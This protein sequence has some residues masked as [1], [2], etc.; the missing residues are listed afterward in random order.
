[1]KVA[2]SFQTLSD[3]VPFLIDYR[4]G[5][6]NHVREL[7]RQAGAPE[8][9]HY[10]AYA[11]NTGALC[12][13]ENFRSAGGA[14]SSREIAL[15]KA[16]GE[17]IE[18]YCCAMY[19][20]E[21][22]PLFS[23][24]AAPFPCVSPDTFALYTERQYRQPAF[25]YVPFTSQVPIRWAR[26]INL[27]NG[28][29]WHVPAAMTVLPYAFDEVHGER[30]VCQR[31]STGL[32]CHRSF[33]EAA[34]SGICEVIERDA[35]TI[36]WQAQLA[37][38][39]LDL[40]TLSEQNRDLVCRFR[41]VGDSV[42][43]LNITTDAGV[44][45]ILGILRGG[46]DDA[47][48]FVFAAST[49]LDPEKAVQK[50]LEELAH[51]RQLAQ[52]LKREQPCFSVPPP[53]DLIID[54]DHH[55]QFYTDHANTTLAKFIMSAKA[56]CAFEDI[57]CL[58]STDLEQNLRILVDKVQQTGHTVYVSDL[59]TPDVE[60]LGLKVVRAIIPGFHPLFM[61][62]RLRALG[63]IR[64]WEVPQRLGHKGRDH[65]EGDNPA[66]HPYP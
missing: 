46:E 1:M 65:A 41:R 54:K 56:R 23:F 24:E 12:K 51:T 22:F 21:E 50:S 52:Q 7:R 39:H 38:P 29:I 49:D 43:L 59:T 37:P 63:G 32:A 25:P 45:S 30:P 64:L 16:I 66:P 31:I 34:A 55:V 36:T 14:S 9:F 18:R 61:G 2:E 47:P 57:E 10:F 28:E 8:F 58:S 44:P 48:A 11:C 6:I 53:Y 27:H 40:D 13:Q 4:I 3:A 5:I 17:A 35:F 20:R 15:A 33:A 42:N 26:T 60:A 19:D 62:H